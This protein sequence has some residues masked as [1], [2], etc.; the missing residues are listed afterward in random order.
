M[1]RFQGMFAA[2]FFI[3][4][5]TGLLARGETGDA[6]PTSAVCGTCHAGIQKQWAESL[7]A[8]SLEDPLYQAVLAWAIRDKGQGIAAFCAGCHSVARADTDGRSSSVECRSCHQGVPGRKPGQRLLIDP[9]T[10]VLSPRK[11]SDAPHPVEVTNRLSSGAVCE[12]CHAELRNPRGITLC[13]TGI[14][15]GTGLSGPGCAGCHMNPAGHRF[16]GS[17]PEL[18]ARAG[19]L[20]LDL[21]GGALRATVINNGAGHG[22]PTGSPLRQVHLVVRF[23]DASGKNLRTHR[24]IFA[25]VFAGADGRAPVPPWRAA[26][27][28]SDTR[29]GRRE[30]RSFSYPIPAGARQVEAHLVYRRMPGKIVAR[31][32]LGDEPSTEAIT[33]VRAVLSLP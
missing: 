1:T 3:V 21:T 31:L 28:A 19:T 10:P 27:V 9:A 11:V 15:A 22:L 16:E 29:L 5:A 6:G 20:T 25:R 32:G 23:L 7:H 30:R 33:M 14:E 18:L 26:S 17:S 12:P 4:L 8:R 2:A 13:S 24:E